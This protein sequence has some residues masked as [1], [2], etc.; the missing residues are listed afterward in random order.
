MPA[1]IFG[2]DA[3]LGTLEEGKLADLT[4]VD[5]DPF[6]DFDDLIRTT[7]VLRGGVPFQQSDLV[8]SFEPVASRTLRATGDDWLEVGRHMRR[9]GCCDAGI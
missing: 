2:A 6:T 7:A 5:G 4:I 8:G 1:R 3:D 9:E